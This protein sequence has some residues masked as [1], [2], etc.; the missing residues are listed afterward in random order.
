MVPIVLTRFRLE[1]MFE[2]YVREWETWKNPL[3]FVEVPSLDNEAE[4][5]ESRP[6]KR[7]VMLQNWC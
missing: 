5:E 4:E 3:L 7:W 1:E 6:V 2:R